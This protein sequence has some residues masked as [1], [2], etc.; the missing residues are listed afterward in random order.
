MPH[1]SH[2]NAASV[3]TVETGMPVYQ[4]AASRTAGGESRFMSSRP[5]ALV[6]FTRT[7][8]FCLLLDSGCL[9]MRPMKLSG[10]QTRPIMNESEKFKVARAD[11]KR[12]RRSREKDL[13]SRYC[14]GVGADPLG[15]WVS[16]TA[17]I[18]GRTALI[19]TNA[20]VAVV[21]YC[22]WFPLARYY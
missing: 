11:R 15:P 4:H 19:T 14:W 18:R 6:R 16:R 3:R 9:G 1:T 21:K 2:P 8:V 22:K 5:S 7:V 12:P 13:M 17:K 20:Y 10:A